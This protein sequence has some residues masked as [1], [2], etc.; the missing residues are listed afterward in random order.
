[1]DTKCIIEKGA[2][3]GDYRVYHVIDKMPKDIIE[4]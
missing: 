2:L 1:M 3:E 4:K